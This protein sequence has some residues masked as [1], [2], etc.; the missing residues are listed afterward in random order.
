MFILH[1]V[2]LL[3]ESCQYS[4]R[5]EHGY[6]DRRRVYWRAPDLFTEWSGRVLAVRDRYR[7]LFLELVDGKLVEKSF[8]EEEFKAI[9][10]Q[11]FIELAFERDARKYVGVGNPDKV[12]TPDEFNVLLIVQS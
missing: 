10:S 2:P 4:L 9:V 1:S 11:K 8:E 3:I 5:V 7:A 12:Y 6:G